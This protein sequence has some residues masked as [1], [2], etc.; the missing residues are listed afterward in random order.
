MPTLTPQSIV[1]AL[2]A[3]YQQIYIAY[4][5]GLDSHVLL[6][7]CAANDE[8]R[9]HITAVYIHHGLQT[10]ADAWQ[11][12]CQ[13][14]AAVLNVYFLA[15]KV[16][17]QAVT[18]ESPEAAARAARYN[19]FKALL[20]SD[21]L[22]LVAHHREDQ[23]ETL[24]LQLFRGAGLA[25]LA[26]MPKAQTF[27]QGQIIRPLLDYAKTDLQH[28]AEQ[29]QLTWVEDPSNASPDFDRNFLRNQVMPLLKTRWPSLDKTV[30]RTAQHCAEA[31][32]WQQNWANQQL[33]KITDQQGCLLIS[34]WREYPDYQRNQLLRQ[35]LHAYA[36]RP[37]SQ[38]VLHGIMQQVINAQHD[39]TPELFLQG[40]YIKKFQ[41]KLYCLSAS[42][43]QPETTSRIWPSEQAQITLANGSQLIRKEIGLGIDKQLW[44]NHQVTI[45]PRQ[46]GEKIKLPYRNGHHA[47]KKLYQEAN[48]PPWEREIRP[49]IYIDGR[50]AAVPGLWVAEWAL[51][52]D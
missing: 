11:C 23:A 37:P 31:S 52:G 43:L 44:Q 20:N 13:Q 45:M 47:L 40:F 39:K 42:Y 8:I 9:Q 50:L 35:W 17:A 7:L 1:Q 2:P 33:T 5:G 34:A 3:K 26:A 32:Q 10:A 21:D 36:I 51:G 22:L 24:L 6:H 12:H 4:S 49:L 15:I 48:R 41:E 46:G 30:A 38:A 18:G 14:Q 28:Y 29:Q 19:A 27:A 25:G 16:H